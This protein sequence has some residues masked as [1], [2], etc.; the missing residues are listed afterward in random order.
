[1][2]ADV[3]IVGGGPVGLWTA[4]Q[5]K[6]RDPSMDVQVYERH[7]EYQRSHVL[8]LENFSMLVYSKNSSDPHERAFFKAIIGEDSADDTNLSAAFKK[9]MGVKFIRTNDLEAALKAYAAALNIK[10]THARVKDPEALMQQHPECRLFVAADGARSH[11]RAQLLDKDAVKYA[12]LQYVVEVKYEARGNVND[13]DIKHRTNSKL[14]HLATEYIG[15][16]K[17]GITPVTLR[18]FVDKQT[19][20]N[21]PVAGFSDALKLG[22]G[23]IAAD[24][25]QDIATYMQ[26]RKERAGEIFKPGS[27]KISKVALSLYAADKFALMKEADRAWFFVG[28]AA[29]GVPYFRALNSGMI[30]GSQLAFVLTRKLL[31]TQAKVHTYNFFRP[32]DVAWEFTAALGKDMAL[33][34]YNKARQLFQPKPPR[35][36]KG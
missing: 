35:P 30:I 23:R 1:M 27:E 11:M 5:I 18:F 8:R 33:N 10:V 26:A 16:E 24:M 17:D 28:D 6:K 29:M 14:K 4:I 7:T 34:L 3:V 25:A 9:T 13:L 20:D 12:P 19:F 2:C 15:E 31:P 22:D 32:F 36:P 21:F